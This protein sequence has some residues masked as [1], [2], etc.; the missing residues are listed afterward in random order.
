[1][2]LNTSYPQYKKLDN[3][4][5]FIYNTKK[6]IVFKLN[7]NLYFRKI[8]EYNKNEA[9]EPVK[10][11]HTVGNDTLWVFQWWVAYVWLSTKT[12]QKETLL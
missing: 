4:P 3:E 1:M 2:Q 6:A 11:R 9:V 5:W 10:D 8:T 7:I 12:K